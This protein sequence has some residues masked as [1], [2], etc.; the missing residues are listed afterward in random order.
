LSGIDSTAL[1]GGLEALVEEKVRASVLT[2]FREQYATG[3]QQQELGNDL[4]LYDTNY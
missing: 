3:N 2:E 1:C 4:G